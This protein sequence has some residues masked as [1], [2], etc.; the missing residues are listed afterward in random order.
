MH[1]STHFT[2]AELTFSQTAVRAGLD[3]TPAPPVVERLEELSQLLLEPVRM[4]FGPVRVTS[5][6]R[7]LELNRRIGSKDTSQ[8]IRGE[9]ADIL[10][11]VRPL[12]LCRWIADQRLPFHQL[13]H[14][15]GAWCHVSIPPIGVVPG[16]VLL[17]VDR[18]GT[19]AGLHEVRTGPST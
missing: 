4:H 9:A 13:I 2:L 14:E 17:T 11:A 3:N 8:H 18:F 1:L 15:Y 10:C 7:C 5:G 16:R 19:R 6:Y 12:A